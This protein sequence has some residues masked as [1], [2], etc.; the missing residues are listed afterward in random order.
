MDNQQSNA[1]FRRLRKFPRPT[2]GHRPDP[3]QRSLDRLQRLDWMDLN[4]HRTHHKWIHTECE[5]KHGVRTAGT[6][7]MTL[8]IHDFIDTISSRIVLVAREGVRGPP[9]EGV[10]K[11][12]LD[13]PCLLMEG[14][15][16]LDQLNLREQL[17]PRRGGNQTD[18]RE[19]PQLLHSITPTTVHCGN[20]E[21]G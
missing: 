1:Q 13:N 19:E 17:A 15:L 16:R 2:E 11:L 3:S 18:N 4:L 8:C 6:R 9:G 10:A 20:R 12:T 14:T 7:R 21:E 5:W